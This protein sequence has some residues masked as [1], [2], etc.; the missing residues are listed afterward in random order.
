MPSCPV[1]HIDRPV[2]SDD[3]RAAVGPSATAARESLGV[4]DALKNEELT[5]SRSYAAV[6]EPEGAADFDNE[7]FCI[8]THESWALFAR[9]VFESVN[10]AD[11]DRLTA[12]VGRAMQQRRETSSRFSSRSTSPISVIAWWPWQTSGMTLFMCELVI[13]GA[14]SAFVA[15]VSSARTGRIGS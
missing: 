10:C 5:L 14:W 8:A 15:H 2:Q 1:S 6:P 13:M 12:G 3:E 4:F 7:F 9:G 11:F